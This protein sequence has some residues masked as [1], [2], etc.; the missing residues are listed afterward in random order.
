MS[1]SDRTEDTTTTTSSEPEIWKE[2]SVNPR[3]E[4]SNLGHVRN[5]ENT[6]LLKPRQV[7][8]Y[9]KVFMSPERKEYTVAQ[10]VATAFVENLNPEEFKFVLHKNGDKG[11]DRA[12]NLQWGDRR[13]IA[14]K[15]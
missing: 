3:Y 2:T 11:D 15:T 10:L 6:K 1:S 7:G 9:N 5:K 4:V 8:F 13:E 14:K 12:C